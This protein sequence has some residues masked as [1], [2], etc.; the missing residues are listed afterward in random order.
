MLAQTHN[1]YTIINKSLLMTILSY[2]IY[3]EFYC[4]WYILT[5]FDRQTCRQYPRILAYFSSKLTLECVYL[6]AKT[7]DKTP[8]GLVIA[9]EVRMLLSGGNDLL[10]MISSFNDVRASLMAGQS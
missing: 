3:V 9:T 8:E 1:S 4:L 10:Q 2:N 6:T 7:Q 5:K